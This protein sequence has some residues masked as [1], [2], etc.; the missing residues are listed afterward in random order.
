MSYILYEN[1]RVKNE[2]LKKIL[3]NG[4]NEAGPLI[5]PTCLGDDLNYLRLLIRLNRTQ[6]ASSAFLDR[7]SLSIQQW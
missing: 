7:R 6:E 1:L 2:F 4:R 3:K 5:S